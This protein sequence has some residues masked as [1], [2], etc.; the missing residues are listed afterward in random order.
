M[1]IIVFNCLIVWAVA[2]VVK[3]Q[4]MIYQVMILSMEQTIIMNLM[5]IAVAVEAKMI[6][7]L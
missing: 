7:L 2:K 4:M 5:V 3:L 1:T 6:V